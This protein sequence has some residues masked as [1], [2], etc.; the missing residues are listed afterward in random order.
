MDTIAEKLAEIERKKAELEAEIAER[1]R[2][3]YAQSQEALA[4]QESVL[5]EA[6]SILGVP[7]ADLQSRTDSASSPALKIVPITDKPAT[8]GERR[9]VQKYVMSI[10]DAAAKAMVDKGKSLT[11]T[12]ISEYL[13]GI[14]MNPSRNTVRS[15]LVQYDKRFKR[16]DVGVYDLVNR[17][18][19]EARFREDSEARIAVGA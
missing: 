14:G 19:E 12:E 11:V 7:L 10:S 13:D 9:F 6:A 1:I 15:I 18:Q 17:E 2:R 4:H 16:V 8:T 5:V 3:E